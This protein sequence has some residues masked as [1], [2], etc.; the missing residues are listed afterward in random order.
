LFLWENK[1]KLSEKYFLMIIDKGNILSMS[2]YAFNLLDRFYGLTK[3][4]F[5]EEYYLMRLKRGDVK[6]MKFYA[7]NLSKGLYGEKK[8]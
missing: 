1:T 2:N 6:S 7:Q 3:K 4:H 5:S 8:N